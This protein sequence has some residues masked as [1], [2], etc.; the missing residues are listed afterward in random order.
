[1]S[2]F[3][4]LQHGVDRQ[5][6]IKKESPSEKNRNN[7]NKKSAK[8]VVASDHRAKQSVKTNVLCVGQQQTGKARDSVINYENVRKREDKGKNGVSRVAYGRMINQ[9]KKILKKNKTKFV[10]HVVYLTFKDKILLLLD[11]KHILILV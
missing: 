1:M 2:V 6:S 3:D 10:C 11:L 9:S 4:K 8:S 7:Q 5:L